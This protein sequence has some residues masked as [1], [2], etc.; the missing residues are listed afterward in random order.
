MFFQPYPYNGIDLKNKYC[1]SSQVKII[2]HYFQKI[3]FEIFKIFKETIL[4]QPIFTLA[5]VLPESHV[6]KMK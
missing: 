6:P 3:L 2:S 4:A 1:Q 5:S